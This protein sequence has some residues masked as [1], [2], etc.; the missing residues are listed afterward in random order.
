VTLTPVAPG[1]IRVSF[2]Y[3]WRHP[4]MLVFRT[5]QNEQIGH[6]INRLGNLRA[7]QFDPE[8]LTTTVTELPREEGRDRVFEVSAS[9]LVLSS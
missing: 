4:D 3:T 2:R 1:K 9:V 5:A 6:L 8:T 7:D